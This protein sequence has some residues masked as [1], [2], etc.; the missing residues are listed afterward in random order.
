MDGWMGGWVGVWV[1]GCK[2]VYSILTCSCSRTRLCR[3]PDLQGGIR[4]AVA[5]LEHVVGE[6][7]VGF[8]PAAAEAGQAGFWSGRIEE[9]Q[10]RLTVAKLHATV[11]HPIDRLSSHDSRPKEVKLVAA[12][13]IAS[14][15]ASIEL[16]RRKLLPH[17]KPTAQDNLT[18]I[19]KT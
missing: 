10:C 9:A 14:C 2:Y 12:W 5:D 3:S 16:E 19:P 1:G 15:W 4:R 11:R 7:R 13:I 6:S 17:Q 18:V 8:S